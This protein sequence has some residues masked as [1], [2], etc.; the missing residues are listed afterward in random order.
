MPAPE[1]NSAVG[2]RTEGNPVAPGADGRA[3]GSA[4]TGK[5]SQSQRAKAGDA[6][7][8]HPLAV[9]VLPRPSQG[10]AAVGEQAQESREFHPSLPRAH[11]KDEQPAPKR[12]VPGAVHAVFILAGRPQS[13][14]A[15]R[16]ERTARQKPNDG[17]RSGRS[18]SIQGVKGGCAGTHFAVVLPAGIR[19]GKEKKYVER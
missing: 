15:S 9:G 12:A 3:G 8:V 1:G 5:R 2:D 16:A 7:E 11:R 6:A 14:G 13:G 10:G 4:A 17:Q 19:Q 18:C